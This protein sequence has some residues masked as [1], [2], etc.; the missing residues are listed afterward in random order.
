M[1]NLWRPVGDRTT[2]LLFAGYALAILLFGWKAYASADAAQLAAPGAWV[3]HALVLIAA[4]LLVAGP[5]PVLLILAGSLALRAVIANHRPEEALL[6]FPAAEWPLFIALPCLGLLR[7]ARWIQDGFR[8]SGAAALGFAGLHKINADYFDAA[9]TCN[10]LSARLSDWWALPESLHSW[11]TPTLVVAFELGAPLLLLTIPRVGVVFSLLLLLQFTG[12]GATALSVVIAVTVL[13]WLPAEDLDALFDGRAWTL[14]LAA[15]PAAFA[16]HALYRG[17][18]SWSQYALTHGLFGFFVAF[19]VWRLVRWGP[20][21]PANPFGS[22]PRVLVV[23]AGLWL[24]NGLAPYSG[25]KFQYS[26]AMLSNLRVDDERHNS[27]IFPDWLRVTEHD[28]FVHVREATYLD[29][30]G[31]PL[32]GGAVTPGLWAPYELVRQTDIARSVGERLTFVGTHAGREV[33]EE[34]LPELPRAPLFQKHLTPGRQ[35]CVH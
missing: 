23:L 18:W 3:L 12:I 28:P 17:P 24:A 22:A 6:W 20:G 5:R 26:F 15:L 27:L 7:Q 14:L 29:P 8:I 19:A 16:S 4:S 35:E 1:V 10:R 33:T 2:R 13:A 21:T 30:V 32:T 11:V 25:L 31:R 34:D 9:V